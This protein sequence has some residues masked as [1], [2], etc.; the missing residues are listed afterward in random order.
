VRGKLPFD[1]PLSSQ[2][3]VAVVD[4]KLKSTDVPGAVLLCTLMHQRYPDFRVSLMVSLFAA[5]QSTFELMGLCAPQKSDEKARKKAAVATKRGKGPK[6]LLSLSEALVEA[7]SRATMEASLEEEDD[8]S[9][10]SIVKSSAAQAQ[11]ATAGA[12]GASSSSG[13]DAKNAV[14]RCR[15]LLRLLWELF[16]AGV[17]EDVD[18][19]QVCVAFTSVFHCLPGS[20]SICIWPGFGPFIDWRG[21]QRP[22]RCCQRRCGHQRC[23]FHHSTR[24]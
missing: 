6:G 24:A 12:A 3:A 16:R 7:R 1:F 13:E 22:R 11:A 15:T 20:C 17:Y 4:E 9:G 18:A 8:L 2:I 10:M 14:G 21:G 19:I 5:L 23:H